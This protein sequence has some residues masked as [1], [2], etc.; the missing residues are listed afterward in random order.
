MEPSVRDADKPGPEGLGPRGV[1]HPDPESM[2]R[3]RTD[4]TPEE[5]ALVRRIAG[6]TLQRLGY[7]DA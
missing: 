1:G 4:L 6:A 7:P 3:W 2:G 5:Q